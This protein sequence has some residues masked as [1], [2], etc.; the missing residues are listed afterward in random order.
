MH[1]GPGGGAVRSVVF[2]LDGTL[3]DTA[4]DLIAAANACLAEVGAAP[5]D[6][7]ADRATAFRGGRAMLRLGL[8]RSPGLA[9]DEALVDLLYAR[10]LDHYGAAI[11]VHTRLFPG[12]EAALD[13]LSAEGVALGICTNKPEALARR[14]VD[15]LG[16]APRFGV[17]VGADSLARRKPDPLP[18]R[19]AIAALGSSPGRCLMLG[20]TR[21]DHDTARAAG[22]RVALVT[23]GAEGDGVAA[24]GPDALVGHF[25]EL[26]GL[27]RRLLG[28]AESA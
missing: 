3:A 27:V 1:A 21:T 5:L 16:I 7:R 24:H 23:F 9:W 18:L 8:S 26:P 25:D 4:A 28:G 10:L 14:L 11:C 17:L 6:P 20:D 2:D 12:V 19:S 15:A 13:R 22:A